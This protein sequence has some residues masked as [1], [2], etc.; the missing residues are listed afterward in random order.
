M[1]EEST[2]MTVESSEMEETAVSNDDTEGQP[3]IVQSTTGG[4]CIG[5][6]HWL[7][8]LAHLGCY[9]EGLEQWHA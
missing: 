7:V 3:M 4:V 2:G 8:S 5:L 6:G 1:E 9:N